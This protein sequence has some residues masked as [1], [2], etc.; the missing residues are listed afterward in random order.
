MKKRF[1]KITFFILALSVF[2]ACAPAKPKNEGWIQLF[3][4]KD[5]KDWNIKITG[6]P[7][8]E[9]FG[10]TFRVEDGLMKVRYDQYKNFDGHFGHIFYKQPYSHY[11]IR[12]EYRFVGDQCPGGRQR[13]VYEGNLHGCSRL[14]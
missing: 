14:S 3:N 6:F 8:N 10:N 7:L 5:L 11:K 12:V 2:L 1:L 4:G 13:S 9:N